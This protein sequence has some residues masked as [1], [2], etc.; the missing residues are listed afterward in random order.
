MDYLLDEVFLR[1]LGRLQFMTKGRLGGRLSGLHVSPRAGMSVEFAD[2]RE[3]HP[4]DDIRYVDWNIYGRLEKLLVKSFI[5]ESDLPIYLL[6]DVSASMQLGT[7]PKV[8]YAARLA[9]ALAHLGL[10]SMDRVGVFPFAHRLLASIP[11]QH[12]TSHVRRI[13]QALSTL[14]AQ[15]ETAF[16]RSVM[17]FLSLTRETGL[18]LILSD[19]LFPTGVKDAVARLLYRGDE[20]AVLQILA[21]EEIDPSGNETAQIVDVETGRY[22]TLNLGRTTLE[23][24]RERFEQHQA[25]LQSLMDAQRI[26]L[27]TIPTTRT[28]EQVFFEDLREGGIVR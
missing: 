19:L 2:Y 4:G 15:D 10:R 24:Y 20:V 13:Y 1:R 6:I 7:P 5:H 18:V 28:L 26:P 14:T 23:S 3:Y 27:F 8:E 21:P 25:E 22:V 16:E 9:L 17:D 11:P 12:G